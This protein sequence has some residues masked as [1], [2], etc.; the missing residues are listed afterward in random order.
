VG[1]AADTAADGTAS[2][3]QALDGGFDLLIPDVM[4]PRMDGFET[5]R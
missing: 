1:I 2:L 3:A 5:L 4:L